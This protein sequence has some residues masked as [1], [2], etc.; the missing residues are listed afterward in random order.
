[1]GVQEQRRYMDRIDHTPSL[2][3]ATSMVESSCILA[4]ILGSLLGSTLSLKNA[5]LL[6]ML[7]KVICLFLAVFCLPESLPEEKR[8][9]FTWSSLLPTAALRVIF[10]SPLVEKLTALGIFDS[11]HYTGFYVLFSQLL[12]QRL[13]V[14]Q[15]VQVLIYDIFWP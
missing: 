14:S 11:F 2:V 3:M 4:S 13:K 12:G 5:M 9:R 10:Q 15:Q 8:V 1:M 6:G 7:G